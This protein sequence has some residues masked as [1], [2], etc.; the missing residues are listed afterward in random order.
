MAIRY[1]L[2]MIAGELRELPAGDSIYGTINDGADL[3]FDFVQAT[4]SDTWVIAHLLGK[5]PAVT[6]VDSAGSEVE[7]SINHT[8]VNNLTI[9]FSAPFTGKAFLN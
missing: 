1:P 5:F 7:G 9:S 6:V 8:D 2:V 3:H 4:A